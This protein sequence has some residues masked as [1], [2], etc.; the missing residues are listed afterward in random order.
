M[1][2]PSMCMARALRHKSQT[3]ALILQNPAQASLLENSL[4]ERGLRFYEVRPS[5]FT[6]EPIPNYL[7]S[8]P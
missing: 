2:I 5:V 1:G 4:A 3:V 8:Q 6:I 7:R